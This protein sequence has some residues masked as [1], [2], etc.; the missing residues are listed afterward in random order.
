MAHG[1]KP[2]VDAVLGTD[3]GFPF[4]SYET[5]L[6]PLPPKTHIHDPF[7]GVTATGFEPGYANLAALGDAKNFPN[8]PLKPAPVGPHVFEQRTPL[9]KATWRT[10]IPSPAD[11]KA[12]SGIEQL[13]RIIDPEAFGLPDNSEPDTI[14]DRDTARDRARL[15]LA[16][17]REPTEE[18]LA[19]YVGDIDTD[20]A[21]VWETMVDAALSGG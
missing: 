13:A 2:T 16:A 11:V 15:V 6:K 21:A 7:S 18:M 10:I 17:L 20:A 14:T 4:G 8:W 12:S 5:W 3:G 19:P 1:D 9:P